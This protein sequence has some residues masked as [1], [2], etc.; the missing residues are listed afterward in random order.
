[1][2]KL[3][4]H[5]SIMQS[6]AD[7]AAEHRLSHAYIFEGVRG[8]GKHTA[9]RRL[10]RMMMCPKGGCG[11]CDNC[12]KTEAG[13]HPDVTVADESYFQN[14]KVKAGSVEAMRMI[15]QD[16]YTKP[17]M[18]PMK[19]Y[20]IPEADEMLAPAQ[21]SLLKILEEP[22][23]YCV[24]V[25]L[26]ENANKLLETVRSRSVLV[27]F[28]PLNDEDMT[29][30]LRSR[31]D[32]KTAQLLLRPYG[33]I[34]GKALQ[35]AEDESFLQRRNQ[36]A[37]LFCS[38]FQTG[39]LYPMSTFMEKERDSW[40]EVLDGLS[41]LTAEAAGLF[42]GQQGSDHARRLAGLVSVGR[43]TKVFSL[44]QKATVKLQANANFS[45]TVT[46]LLMRCGQ[47]AG[48]EEENKKWLK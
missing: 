21:N 14:G 37:E 15:R 40:E 33:G 32:E 5:D 6:L 34:P 8:V 11:L 4:G 30:F 24:F 47:A 44:L 39:D 17:F 48:A 10:S 45:L 42:C 3:F 23:E 46:E 16:A 41:D 43:L 38:F 7:G 26:C 27:R 18:G 1:M 28:L 29:A 22:P 20:V 2:E 19:L 12:M 9:A 31:Y 25:L 35:I 36:A 13:S